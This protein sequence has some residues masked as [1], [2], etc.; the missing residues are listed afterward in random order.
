MGMAIVCARSRAGL[1]QRAQSSIVSLHGSCVGLYLD[2]V[3]T[4]AEV[5][6]KLR[7]KYTAGWSSTAA[8]D[9]TIFWIHDP[10]YLATS[11][12]KKYR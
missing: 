2:S 11:G 6:S 10:D 1:G 4:G 7:R 8:P 5:K 3:Q 9:K 12:G